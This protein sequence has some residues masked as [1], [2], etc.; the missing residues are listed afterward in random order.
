MGISL[1]LVSQLTFKDWLTEVIQVYMR[2]II[3]I[4]NFMKVEQSSSV[5]NSTGYPG[6]VIVP[7]NNSSKFHRLLSISYK[8]CNLIGFSTVVI[9]KTLG[10][11][12]QGIKAMWQIMNINMVIY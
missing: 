7:Q 8:H 3:S 4:N 5:C 12:K 2:G 1:A 6:S 9:S 10:Y 11:Q